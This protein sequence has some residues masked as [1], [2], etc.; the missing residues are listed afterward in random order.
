MMHKLVWYVWYIEVMDCSQSRRAIYRNRRSAS[1]YT[2]GD[3][4]ASGEYY[5][6]Q[7]ADSKRARCFREYICET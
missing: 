1:R 7:M 5:R 2:S 6:E 3:S 4:I